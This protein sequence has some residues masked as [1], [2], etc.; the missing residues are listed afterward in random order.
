MDEKLD[1][2]NELSSGEDEFDVDL[3]ACG[4]RVAPG[5]DQF[6]YRQWMSQLGLSTPQLARLL[7]MVITETNYRA[8]LSSGLRG[9]ASTRVARFEAMGKT[10]LS[11]ALDQVNRETNFDF[12]KLQRLVKQVQRQG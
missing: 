9:A 11:D 3:M 8:P 2:L 4:C 7:D 12:A 6:T 10:K 1:L 5:A